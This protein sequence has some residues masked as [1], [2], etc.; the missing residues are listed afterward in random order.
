MRVAYLAMGD[1]LGTPGLRQN[2]PTVGRTVVRVDPLALDIWW[3][4]GFFAK[5]R[6]D[7]RQIVEQGQ[8]QN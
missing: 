4:S 8:A 3:F 5:G 7:L 6:G 1:N 2:S